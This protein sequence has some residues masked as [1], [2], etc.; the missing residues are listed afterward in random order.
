MQESKIAS[1]LSTTGAGVV[2]I[3]LPFF[4]RIF[5]QALVMRFVRLREYAQL[6]QEGY[7][8]NKYS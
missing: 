6:P 7:Y 4:L 2:I 8:I 5:A 3:T 1:N